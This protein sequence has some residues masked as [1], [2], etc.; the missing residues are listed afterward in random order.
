MVFTQNAASARW[1]LPL[2]IVA[3]AI[4]TPAESFLAAHVTQ[5]VCDYSNY[6]HR[7]LMTSDDLWALA[8]LVGLFVLVAWLKERAGM[9]LGVVAITSLLV[10]LS[11]CMDVWHLRIP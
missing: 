8:F 9:C 11:V 3:A 10:A 1:P 5:T 4:L 6:W 7:Q 2:Q